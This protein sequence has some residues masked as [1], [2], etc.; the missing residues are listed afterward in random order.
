MTTAFITVWDSYTNETSQHYLPIDFGTQTDPLI[1]KGREKYL[2]HEA[3]CKETGE[4]PRDWN[5][6]HEF[7]PSNQGPDFPH[8]ALVII[9]MNKNKD[10]STYA[11]C[12]HF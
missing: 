3:I 10:V 5:I 4:D 7:R 2:I 9:L 6:V 1:N 12:W 11:V 8:D